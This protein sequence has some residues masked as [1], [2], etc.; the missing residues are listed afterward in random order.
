MR[1]STLTI[2]H[3]WAAQCHFCAALRELALRTKVFILS[4]AYP[5]L[6]LECQCCCP[7]VAWQRCPTE[8]PPDLQLWP[9]LPPC[10]VLLPPCSA[11]HRLPAE[12]E[13]YKTYSWNLPM[14]SMIILLIGW[15]CCK[16][17]NVLQSPRV[18]IPGSWNPHLQ[19]QCYLF[20]HSIE[21]K[22]TQLDGCIEI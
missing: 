3:C 2:E 16:M 6:V 20:W 12:A 18:A 1:S 5:E 17:M 19:L 9:S 15:I 14:D 13:P 7:S 11:L 22:K 8:T 10:L 4:L 21:K